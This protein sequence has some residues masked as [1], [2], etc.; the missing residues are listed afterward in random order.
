VTVQILQCNHNLLHIALNFKLCESLP[1]FDKFIQRVIR[2]QFQQ[3]INVLVIFEDVLESDNVLMIETLVNFN[4]RN[5]FLPC[6]V[7]RESLLWDDFSSNNLLCLQVCDFVAFSETTLT[8]HL[9][10]DIF[11]DCHFAIYL[12]YLF[13]YDR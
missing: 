8:E 2:A 13:F 3:D 5:K 4:F 9:T 6:S 11:L 1:P 10:A 7:L 12:R